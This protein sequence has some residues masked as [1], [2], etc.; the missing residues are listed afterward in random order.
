MPTSPDSTSPSIDAILARIEPEWGVTI[1]CGPGWY[2]LLIGLDTSLWWL[3][4]NYTL[5][6]VKEKFGGLRYR[7]GR[8]APA[9]LEGAHKL[10]AAAE[11]ASFTICEACGSPGQLGVANHWLSTRCSTCARPDWTAVPR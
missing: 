6:Q 3:D 1:D 9:L 5:V 10:I 4:S 8:F 11:A 7:I 2:P